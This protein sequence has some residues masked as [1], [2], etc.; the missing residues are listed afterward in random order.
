M[1]RLELDRQKLGIRKFSRPRGDQQGPTG[2]KCRGTTTF[3]TAPLPKMWGKPSSLPKVPIDLNAH[4]WQR[5]GGCSGT[6]RRSAFPIYSHQPQKK[7]SRK[8]GKTQEWDVLRVCGLDVQ[9]SR[10]EGDVKQTREM[11]RRYFGMASGLPGGKK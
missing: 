1:S 9:T 10:D 5:G 4:P 2:G 6:H 11:E 8:R 7:K 3:F